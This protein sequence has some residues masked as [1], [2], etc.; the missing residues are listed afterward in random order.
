MSLTLYLLRHAQSAEKQFGESD[1]DRELTSHGMRE[2]LQIGTWLRMQ[3]LFCDA[4]VCSTATRAKATGEYLAEAMQIPMEKFVW[5]DDLYN[6]SARTLFG[7][8]TKGSDEYKSLMI[9]GHNPALS[10]LA[11]YLTKKEIGQIVP[12]G[13]VMIKF[14]V[15]SWQL[16][17]EGSGELVNYIYPEKLL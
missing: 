5:D 14:Q 13:L 6:A 9:I 7:S 2:A 17:T 4:Y 15:D 11:E 16:I 10:Y 8:V 1:K 12:S 3:N